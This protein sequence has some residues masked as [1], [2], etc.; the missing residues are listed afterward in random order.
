MKDIGPGKKI[1]EALPQSQSVTIMGGGYSGVELAAILAS[2]TNKKIRLV[3]SD[4]H[5]LIELS[6]KMA[7]ICRNYLVQLSVEVNE[8]VAISKL[9]QDK[10]LLANGI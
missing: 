1:R 10:V 7:G 3:E 9:E 6:P 4:E 5:L 2:R 8:G